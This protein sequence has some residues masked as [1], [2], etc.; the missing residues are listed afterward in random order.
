VLSPGDPAGVA[1]VQ[2]VYLAADGDG[3]V[4]T[5]DRVLSDLFLVT[6]LK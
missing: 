3:Y 4:Y 1:S 5:Y 6:D 2:L